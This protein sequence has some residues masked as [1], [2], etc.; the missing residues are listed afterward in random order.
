MRLKKILDWI[1]DD[2]SSMIYEVNNEITNE[3]WTVDLSEDDD[4]AVLP[5]NE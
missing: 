4:D 3:K 5:N 1:K 2:A